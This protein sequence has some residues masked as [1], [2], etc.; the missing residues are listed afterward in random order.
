[1]GAKRRFDM[2]TVVSL[3]LLGLF[4]L[5]LLYPLWGLLRQSV[6]NAQ[7]E[8]T[9]EYFSVSSPIVITRLLSLTALRC[10]RPS[11]SSH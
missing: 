6:L 4:A 2:W 11:P 10:R 7:G 8:F 5:F 1:M 9:L 3:T